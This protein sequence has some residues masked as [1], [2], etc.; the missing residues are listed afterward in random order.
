[1]RINFCGWS[2]PSEVAYISST[3]AASGNGLPALAFSKESWTKALISFSIVFIS[4][5]VWNSLSINN[6]LT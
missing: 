6:F 2:L 3:K 1:M 5:T 4:S